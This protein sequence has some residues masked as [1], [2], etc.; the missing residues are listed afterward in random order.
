VFEREKTVHAL[1][2]AAT[3][4]GRS[5]G[6]PQT[7]PPIVKEYFKSLS[8]INI[9]SVPADLSHDIP[10]KMESSFVIYCQQEPTGGTEDKYEITRSE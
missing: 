9:A 2:R 7:N 10:A 8:R 5:T 4:I 3:V 1:D 6:L